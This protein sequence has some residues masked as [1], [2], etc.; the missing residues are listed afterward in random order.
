VY[1]LQGKAELVNPSDILALLQELHR[2]KL[3]LYRRHE[4]GARQVSSY[5]F[6]NTYQYI[7]NREDVQ[8]SWLRAAIEEMGAQ[9]DEPSAPL[10]VPSG[11]GPKVERATIEDDART[12]REF[13]DRWRLRGEGIT[14]ARHRKLIDLM[15]GEA[16]EHQ[17]FFEQA[18]AG[19]DDLLGR[20]PPGSGTGGGV[21][22]TRWIE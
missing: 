13:V 16:R 8:L 7:L 12:A 20:R 14:R 4:A 22:A 2:E 15:L 10:P 19:R 21:M 18:Q 3:A 9:P 5:E 17:R 11:S 1:H 6:N